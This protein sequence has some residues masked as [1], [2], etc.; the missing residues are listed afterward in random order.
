MAKAKPKTE[1]RTGT[2]RKISPLRGMTVPA[3]IAAKAKGWQ[4]R[5]IKALID[6][7]SKAAPAAT[8][9][10]KWA[11]PVL[12]SNGPVAFIKPAIA[13][14]TF[15]FWRGAELD[16]DALEGGD[17]MKHWKLE[18]DAVDVARVTR[19]VKAAVKLNATKGDPT[20]R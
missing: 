7:A 14:V 10:I 5:T 18:A 11:Q 19:L 12:E 15:G 1:G 6:A 13:H 8:W 3:W 17:R 16:D 2:A 4:A 20:K 9:T